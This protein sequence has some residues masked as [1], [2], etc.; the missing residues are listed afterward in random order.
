MR[1]NMERS[2]G[3]YNSQRVLLALTEKGLSRED[4]YQLVQRN[5]MKSWKNRIDFKK[6]LTKDRDV[7]KHLTLKELNTIF[8]MKHYVRNVEYVFKRVFGK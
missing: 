7:R 5:A 2:H 3:L 8:D 6:F 4:S 1:E